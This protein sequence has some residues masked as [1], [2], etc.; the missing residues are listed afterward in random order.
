MKQ[1]FKILKW[2]CKWLTCRTSHQKAVTHWETTINRWLSTQGNL[3]TVKRVKGIRLHVTR[4]LCGQPLLISAHPGIGLNKQGLPKSLGPI[5]PLITDG[6][7]WDKRFVLTMLSISRAIPCRGTVSTQDITSPGV[8]IPSE[9]INHIKDTLSRLR[10]KIDR[11]EW[12]S[13][14]F[15]TKAG[16]NGQAMVGAVYDAFHLS[17]TDLEN[18][19]ILG[20]SDQLIENIRTI[21]SSVSLDK[22]S[23]KFPWKDRGLLRKLSVVSD[24]EAKERVIAIFDYWSQSALKP[25]HETLMK[26]LAKIPGDMTFTQLGSQD[27]LPKVGPYYSMDLH[28]ATD[29]F[30][31]SVQTLVLEHL[32]SSREYAEAWQQIM[33]SKRFSNPWG[34]PIAYAVGQPM[35]A[36]SSWAMFAVTHHVVVRT[37]AMMAGYDPCTFKAYVLLGDDIVIA[38]QKVAEKYQYLMESLGVNLSPAKTHV[39]VDTYEFAKRWYQ[40]GVEIPGIQLKAFMEITNWAQAAEIL[41]VSVSRW[42]LEPLDMEPGSIPSL[43]KALGLRIRDSHKVV[44]FLHLPLQVDTGEIRAHKSK[45][46]ASRFFGEVF[47]C[48]DRQELKEVFVLQSLAEVK[49]A[50]MESGI[51]R[52]FTLGQKFLSELV[53]DNLLESPDQSALLALPIVGAVRQQMLELQNSFESLRSAYYDL[54]EDI[55]FGKILIAMSDPSRVTTRRASKMVVAAKATLVN[56]YKMWAKDYIQTRHH[57]LSESD[58]HV[59]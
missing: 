16:P 7:L 48:F 45:W 31:V 11:P 17:E 6:D 59:P 46:L 22:W 37:A 13:Y 56:R 39:S 18:L 27:H 29:R 40:A 51:K 1:P 49:T 44:S 2:I 33:V 10:W 28:A 25:L 55:V 9:V 15:S 23:D 42:S 43:L 26:F 41:R 12:S 30:P 4:Y 50:L 32:V 47:G 21:T 58:E 52:V 34:D 36:Y 57:L 3:N 35:G 53:K 38:N 20:N 8:V 24:P 54:D 19:R 14:H 5:L